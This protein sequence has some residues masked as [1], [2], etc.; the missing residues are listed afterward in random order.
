VCEQGAGGGGGIF[1]PKREK[2]LDN[3]VLFTEHY[4]E[5]QIKDD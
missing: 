1:G 2:N 5:N 4:L 3:F